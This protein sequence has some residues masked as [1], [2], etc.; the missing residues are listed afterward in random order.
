MDPLL[1]PGYQFVLV[2]AKGK[3]WFHSKTEKNLNENLI[4]ETGD[5]QTLVAAINGRSEVMI[6]VTYGHSNHRALVRPIRN[7][8]LT[9]IVLHDDDF[10]NTPIVLTVGFAFLLLSFL[11]LILGLHQLILLASTYSFSLLKVKKVFPCLVET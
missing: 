7:T 4:D 5:D 3:V 8:G 6:T 1:P 9:L 10:F 11:F 2:D